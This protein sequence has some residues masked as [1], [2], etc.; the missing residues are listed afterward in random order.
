MREKLGFRLRL[1]RERLG[2]WKLLAAFGWPFLAAAVAVLG[3]MA[4]DLSSNATLVTLASSAAAITAGAKHYSELVLNPFRRAI[5]RH[6]KRPDYEEQLGFTAEADHDVRALT[7]VLAPDDDHALA[8]FVDDLDRCSSAHVVEVVEAMNQIFNAAEDHRCAFVLGLDRDVVATSIEVV[9]EDTVARLVAAR[10]PLGDRFG[11]EFLAKLVQLTVAIPQPNAGAIRALLS[12]VTDNAVPRP[13][14][15]LSEGA[16]DRAQAEIR[17]VSKQSLSGVGEAASQ[18]EAG[19][20]EPAVVEEAARRERALLLRDSQEVI[21]A[22]FSAL[23]HL[24]RN[25]RQVKRFHNA[26]RLQLYVANADPLVLFDFTPDQLIALAKWV[27]VRLRWPEFGDDIAEQPELL[28]VL[29]ATANEDAL[30]P[31]QQEVRDVLKARHGRWFDDEALCK[32][33]LEKRRERRI[34]SLPLDTFLR[35]A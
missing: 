8:V 35:V 19:D 24:E 21:D 25:P 17:R 30:S 2:G 15:E 7:R 28:T 6:A 22:E 13:E 20:A 18:I 31:Q 29:E 5:E 27:T 26:F 16:V 14:P 11:L 33:L 23:K 4:A 3:V 9:Y 34:D 12:R 1:E 32:V 10:N